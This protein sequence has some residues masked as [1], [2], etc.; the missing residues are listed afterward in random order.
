VSDS[1]GSFVIVAAVA[2]AAPLVLAF[3]PRLLIP[4]LVLELVAGIVIGPSVLD[5]AEVNQPV[6]VFAE[7]G[8]VVLL[9]LCGREIRL[10]RMRGRVIELAGLGFLISLLLGAA[11]ALALHGAGLTE[12]PLL[13]AVILAASSVSVILIPLRDAHETETSFG[14]Q[15]MAAAAVAEFGAVVLVAF[16]TAGSRGGPET[17]L[18]HLV[19]F[20][21]VAVV[22]ALSLA[23]AERAG[24]LR[25]TLDRLDQTSAQIRV[26]G[27]MALLAII[28]GLG[29]ELGLESVLAAFAVG[30]VRGMS[31]TDPLGRERIEAVALGVFVPFFF[32]ASGLEID[33]GELV[34]SPSDMAKLP[35]FLA[36]L[37]VVR[38]VPALLYR[39]SMTRPRVGAAALLQATSLSLIIVATQIGEEVGLLTGETSTALVGAGL[40]SV[41]LYPA[42]ALAL[43]RR[44]REE[45]GEA[46]R[47]EPPEPSPGSPGEGAAPPL[48]PPGTG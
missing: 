39:G 11:G 14:Q 33:I 24:F 9:Y 15:V 40:F 38:G 25:A 13:V 23:K 42:F 6:E 1:Y 45:T 28:V 41:L 37:L 16:S 36:A 17:E 48:V 3:A 7:V 18:V 26:R 5:I 44:D 8:L 10:D 22:L 2:F 31:D 46:P 27:D 43:I 32:V 34:E 29:V 47:S 4:S 19:A 12:S 21:V 35:L 20:G 30:L